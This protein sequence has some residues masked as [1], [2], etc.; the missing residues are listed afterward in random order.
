MLHCLW[1]GEEVVT[2]KCLFPILCLPGNTLYM[3][4][5]ADGGK[6]CSGPIYED[7]AVTLSHKPKPPELD[8][9]VDPNLWNGTNWAQSY[10][11]VT[12]AH[13]ASHRKRQ[14]LEEN[15]V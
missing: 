8:Y 5:G 14:S 13:P 12:V 7:P 2:L 10:D 9:E 1:P 3:L 4:T 11:V 6:V 15:E